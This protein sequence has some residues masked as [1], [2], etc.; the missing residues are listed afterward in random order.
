MRR[1]V[2]IALAI[3][4]MMC[5]SVFGEIECKDEYE[6]FEPI[7]ITAKPDGVP[8]DAMMRGDVEI[9]NAAWLPGF[10]G[11]TY[12]VWA[13]PGEHE[14]E[15]MGAWVQSHEATLDGQTVQILDAVGFYRETKKFTVKPVEQQQPEPVT[16]E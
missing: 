12:Y 13:A 5:T 1:I 8:E 16:N 14:I 7:V 11:N 15:V 2:C 10:S 9:S 6:P 4:G 3:V